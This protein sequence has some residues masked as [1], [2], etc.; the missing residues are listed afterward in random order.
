MGKVRVID[1]PYAQAVL[2]KLRDKRTGQV[3]FRK[4]LVR[5][6]RIIGLE[7]IKEFNIK[8]VKVETPIGVAEGVEIPDLRNVV[9]VT[10][11]RAAIPL[12]EGLIKIFPLARQGVI[13]ARRVEEKG[14]GKD[15]TF[16]IEINYVNLPKIKPKDNVIIT[17]PMLATGS[18][19]VAVINEVLKAGKAKRYF[20]ASVIATPV[21]ISRILNTFKDINIKIYTVAI[22]KELNEKGYIVPGL[23][24]AGDR[25]F[26]G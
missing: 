21:G 1:H 3:D 23:G 13:S 11:L 20:I 12:T 18:T 14:M 9:V 2:T 22:D 25:A 6:G 26:G 16:E 19:M 15:Y 8:R 5:L 24:D 4:G 17:D 7:I 10:V